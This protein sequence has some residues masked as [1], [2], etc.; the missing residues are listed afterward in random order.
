M[1]PCIHGRANRGNGGAVAAVFESK[2]Q[3]PGKR[4]MRFSIRSG[5]LALGFV[6]LVASIGWSQQY[7]S[8]YLSR[9][10]RAG[11]VP[12]RGVDSQSLAA[13]ATAGTTLPHWTGSFIADDNTY[14]YRMLGTDP[15]LGSQTTTIPAILIPLKL[16]F[17]DKTVLDATAPVFGQTQSS[18]QLTQASPLFQNVSFAPGGTNVGDTQYIDAFQRANFWNLVSTTS[19]DYHVLFTV[20]TEPVQTLTVPKYFGHTEAGP[21]NRIGYVDFD[22]YDGQLGVIL[23][24]LKIKTNTL[25]VFLNY[26]V[27]QTSG[28]VTYAG[29]HAAFGS[30]AQAYL[31]AGFYDQSIFSYGGDIIFL[32]NEMGA[33]MDDPFANNSVPPWTNPQSPSGPCSR[34]L[35]VGE[36]VSDVGINT[37]VLSGYT[38]HPQD[39]TF[40]GWFAGETPTTTSV[41][42]WYTFGN[43]LTGP[44]VCG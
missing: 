9:R 39:L 36:P 21:G 31:S 26:N 2:K 35:Q 33:T 25:A 3:I 6:V 7:R 32:S 13:Q 38:Y 4:K 11:V 24:R 37:V 23:Y 43:N 20:T 8:A 34:Q 14:S 40:L 42:G 16:V 41:N 1:K 15:S 12:A 28:A 10:V 22:W 17:S 30:P 18:L 29:Y 5:G 27:M 19:P 44:A